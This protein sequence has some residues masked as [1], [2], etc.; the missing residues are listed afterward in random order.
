MGYIWDIGEKEVEHRWN[1]GGKEVG[2][3]WDIRGK[4]QALI[5]NQPAS[6]IL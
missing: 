3:R 1:I 4:H 5:R 6:S 2:H